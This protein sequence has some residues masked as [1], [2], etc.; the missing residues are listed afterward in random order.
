MI[1]MLRREKWVPWR[2]RK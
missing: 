2:R 1:G